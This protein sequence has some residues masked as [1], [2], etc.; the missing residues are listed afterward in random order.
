MFFLVAVLSAA[1]ALLSTLTT[2]PVEEDNFD[3]TISHQVRDTKM[4]LDHKKCELVSVDDDQLKQKVF[5]SLKVSC[6]VLCLFSCS[7]LRQTG[8]ETTMKVKLTSHR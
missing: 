1:A 3:A 7:V 6:V 4:D 5:K 2:P 8:C